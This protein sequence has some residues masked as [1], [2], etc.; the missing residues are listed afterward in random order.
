VLIYINYII[1]LSISLDYTGKKKDKKTQNNKTQNETKEDQIQKDK[2]Q[3]TK[4]AINQNIIHD[5]IPLINDYVNRLVEII[6]SRKGYDYQ[7]FFGNKHYL[8][9][10]IRRI[11]LLKKQ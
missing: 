11:N 4:R 6:V 10:E 7:M 8:K 1:N 5:I 9:G 3:A 2:I